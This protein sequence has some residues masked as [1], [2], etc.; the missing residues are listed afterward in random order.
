MLFFVYYAGLTAI[1]LRFSSLL[2]LSK[3]KDLIW[4][5]FRSPQTVLVAFMQEIVRSKLGVYVNR[6]QLNSRTEWNS[7]ETMHS[8]FVK[9]KAMIERLSHEFDIGL[10]SYSEDKLVRS[11]FLEFIGSYISLEE[12]QLQQSFDQIL[13]AYYASAGHFRWAHLRDSLHTEKRAP[14]PPEDSMSPE[15]TLLSHDVT[16][17]M[18]QEIKT[19][20]ARCVD[21]APRSD[22]AEWVFRVFRQLLNGLCRDH[23]LYAVDCA[24]ERLPKKLGKGEPDTIFLLVTRD[25]NSIIYIL[26]KLFWDTVLPVVRTSLSIYPDCVSKKNE[27]LDA[28]EDKLATGLERVLELIVAH[29]QQLLAKEQ[30]KTDFRPPEETMAV[31][32]NGPCTKAC[33]LATKFLKAKVA[34]IQSCLNGK[35]LELVLR[36]LGMRIHRILLEHVKQM[37]FNSLGGIMLTRDLTEYEKTIE[38][39]NDP[40]V[41]DFFVTMRELSAVTIVKPESIRQLCEEGRLALLDRNTIMSFLQL[42]A[43]YKSAKIDRV[44]K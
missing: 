23:I 22:V 7:I 4:V 37:T 8:A 29:V 25:A 10:D 40:L 2:L 13:R 26:Q 34:Q 38:F 44:F 18:F 41:L 5:V 17:A 14:P 24:A 3:A 28:L 30:K 9:A 19:A 20:V 35:N 43:D 1:Y 27:A 21:L 33:E 31:V 32:L 11:T 15:E 39:L 42:R 16:V 12:L 6:I 36:G